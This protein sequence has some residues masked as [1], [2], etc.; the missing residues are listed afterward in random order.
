MAT[1]RSIRADEL[2]ELLELYRMLN[3]DDPVLG[4]EDPD[5]REQ[6]ERLVEDDL[7]E[8]V[9]IDAS[10]DGIDEGELVASCVLSITPNLTRG[11]QPWAVIE[12]VVTHE[13]HRGQGYGSQVVE[14]ATG[15][16][17]EADCY[18]VMLLTG[19]DEDWKLDFYEGCG[20]DRENKTG[21]V[22]YLDG[23]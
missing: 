1:A 3:P 19:T 11:G 9:V 12:N 18:K 8:L 22:Q 10:G 5:V 2:A 4:P 23:E 17:E 14:Y 15:I 20:F 21:F 7:S 13:N 6:F 16:A